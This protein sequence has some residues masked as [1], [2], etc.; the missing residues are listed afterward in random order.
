MIVLAYVL[1]VCWAIAIAAYGTKRK[2]GWP[3]TRRDI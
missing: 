3:W 2:G 1:V